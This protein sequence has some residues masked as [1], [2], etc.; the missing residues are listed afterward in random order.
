MTE[1]LK[2]TPGIDD[3]QKADMT[4]AAKEWKV[5]CIGTHDS[6]VLETLG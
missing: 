6:N 1:L 4:K 5:L 2:N 3:D